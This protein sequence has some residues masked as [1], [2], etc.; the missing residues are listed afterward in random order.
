MY[1]RVTIA[2]RNV[3][4]AKSRLFL[5]GG[6][7]A[8]VATGGFSVVRADSVSEYEKNKKKYFEEKL[9]SCRVCASPTPFGDIASLYSEITSIKSEEKEPSVED[10]AP[11]DPI[12]GMPGKI[13]FVDLD[14]ELHPAPPLRMRVQVNDDDTIA[15]LLCPADYYELSRSTWTYLHTMAAYFPTEAS[16]RLQQ[17]MVA[18]MDTFS[19]TYPCEHCR[20]HMHKY[21]AAH[22]V[23]ASGCESLSAWVCGLHNDVNAWQGKPL[24]SCDWRYLKRRYK[25]GYDDGECQ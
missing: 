3:L 5:L 20:D 7:T 16:P 12:E 24:V 9:E 4:R 1:S 2:F 13:G 8:A 25:D 14:P 11:V 21:M 15:P 18:F 22:P 10:S 6:I 23:T 17:D 19:R